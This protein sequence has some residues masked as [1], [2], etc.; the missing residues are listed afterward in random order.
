MLMSP[1]MS[2]E[3]EVRRL[4]VFFE[5]WMSGRLPAGDEAFAPFPTALAPEFTMVGPDGVSRDHA[6]IT[7]LV[8]SLHGGRGA[9][10][11]IWI[12]AAQALL[13][14]PGL[15]VVRY[16]ECQSLTDSAGPRDTLRRCT[17][18]LTPAEEGGWRW[19][20]VQETWVSP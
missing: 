4:H 6:A 17:A 20:A 18:V 3:D 13:V 10:F 1:A 19:L 15:A 12:E 16:D 5:E 11:R 9:D 2:P 8:R 14:R 7:A